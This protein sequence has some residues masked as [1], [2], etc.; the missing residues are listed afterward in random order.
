MNDEVK[1]ILDSLNKI[2]NVEYY[3]EDL[4]TYKEC[5]Q[6][7]DYI[8]NLQYKYENQI[9]R[10][11]NLKEQTINL[12]QENKELDDYAKQLEFKIK[13]LA[14]IIDNAFEYSKNCLKNLTTIN[15]EEAKPFKCIYNN[16]LKILNGGD[17]K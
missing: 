2:A 15:E 16:Y 14:T 12:Q 7:L 10:Y 17:E 1:E 4:L 13:I 11:M 9:H 8:T 6:L 3:P 5:K